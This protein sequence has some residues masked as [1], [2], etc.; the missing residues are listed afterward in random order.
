MIGWLKKMWSAADSEINP[1]M[2]APADRPIDVFAP[3]P[4]LEHIAN[5]PRCHRRGLCDTGG[6]L[7]HL[8]QEKE[9][10]ARGRAPQKRG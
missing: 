10:E 7:L 8:K 1:R 6:F 3:D 2:I 9:R 4:Y 5:C